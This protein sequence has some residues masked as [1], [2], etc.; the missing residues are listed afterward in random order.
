MGVNCY[1]LY[2]CDGSYEPIISDN[3]ELEDHVSSYVSLFINEL[4]ITPDTCFY[5][6]KINDVEVCDSTYE[7]EVVTDNECDCKCF[8]YFVK[9]P[10]EI[11]EMIYV[12][13]EDQIMVQEVIPGRTYNICSKIY[14]VFDVEVPIP[15]KITDLCV[16]NQCPPTIPTV[17]P[18]NE[19]DV[20]TIFPMGVDCSV[21]HPTTT[22]S[23]NGAAALIITGGTPPYS[24]SWAIGSNAP[25][26][27]YIGPGRYNATIVDYYG[28]F[29]ANTTC[30]LTAETTTVSEVC[31]AVSGVSKNEVTYFSTESLGFKNGKPYYYIQNGLESVG[32]IFWNQSIDKWVF[33]ESLECQDGFY[34]SL[35]NSGLYYPI[36]DNWVVNIPSKFSIVDSYLGRCV[37][38]PIIIPPTNLCGTL[39]SRNKQSDTIIENINFEPH[40]DI[41]NKNSWLSDDGNYLIYWNNESNPEK[42]VLSGLTNQ[43]FS[44]VNNDPSSP[45]I[46][47]WQILGITNYTNFDVVVG[48]CENNYTISITT[49]V[50]DSS[51]NTN[52]NKFDFITGNGSII[53]TANGGVPP[54]QYSNNG[55]LSYQS[56]PIFNNLTP[57]VYQVYVKDSNNIIGTL[58]NV[59]VGSTPSVIYDLNLTTDPSNSLLFNITTSPLPPGVTITFDFY[60]QST[61][62]YY[63]ENIL[64]QPIYDNL[65]TVN[66]FGPLNL[67]NTTNNIIP[68][69]GPCVVDR[70][71]NIS[72][73]NKIYKGT[74]TIGNNQTITGSLTST[75]INQPNSAC[76]GSNGLANI[77]IQNAVVNNC[78]CCGVNINN[79][80]FE[81]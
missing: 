51:C 72:Q 5:V 34:E 11:A 79:P 62:E 50:S 33:C 48:D 41:N 66:N 61:L 67:V 44:I 32:Y 3:V 52:I 26:L 46:S 75:I 16:N 45:P 78:L 7:V 55:G 77:F 35:D 10:T 31:F 70:P 13:C 15:L 40:D 58:S 59:V 19:C 2:S 9:S 49:S 12:D 22:T 54:Y 53:V 38:N 6:Y 42:W 18:K 68:L 60:H 56:S 47:N 25:A 8:C 43:N 57:G 20:L 63:P 27:N 28:D 39:V 69:T 17:K 80:V 71:I 14:P 1:I 76:S 64:P 81:A 36:G 74:F 65:V 21:I 23:F 24:V 73:N 37:V 29:T 4:N 30:V